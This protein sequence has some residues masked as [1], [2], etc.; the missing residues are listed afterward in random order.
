MRG[1]GANK[2]AFD[3]ARSPARVAMK[4]NNKFGGC[5]WVDEEKKS[6]AEIRLKYPKY[7]DIGARIPRCFTSW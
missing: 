2:Q 6:W 1:G 3:F 7:R 5:C 4:E